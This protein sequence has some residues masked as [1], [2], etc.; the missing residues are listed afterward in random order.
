MC[1]I[2]V[3]VNKST[4]LVPAL[5]MQFRHRNCSP[6]PDFVFFKLFPSRVFLSEGVFFHR[7]RY[8][9]RVLHVP[10]VRDVNTL[11]HIYIY[12]YIYIYIHYIHTYI[13]TY[14]Y[15]YIYI[16]TCI[17]TLCPSSSGTAYRIVW[18]HARVGIIYIYIYIY[19]ERER[20]INDNQTTIPYTNQQTTA[21][22]SRLDATNP[23]SCVVCPS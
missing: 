14:I 23:M 5:A 17:R 21:D 15:I 7:R 12:I 8:E 20:T 10:L 13:H 22:T 2:P 16:H 9:H 3:S 1:H 19:R 4:P 11:M 18:Y 6:A